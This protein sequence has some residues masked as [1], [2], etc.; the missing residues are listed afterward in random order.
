MQQKR[1][2]SAAED[3]PS[4]EAPDEEHPR[5]LIPELYRQF[6]Y[7][8]W[9]TGSGGSVS[10]KMDDEI[11]VAPSGVQKEKIKPEDMF[12]FDADGNEVSGPTPSKKLR[13]SSCFPV[14]M[15][16]FKKRGAG[17]V[18]HTHSPKA[19][20]ATLLWSG[21]EF[22]VANLQMI[23]AIPKG[24]SGKNYRYD[25][26]LVVPI[27]EN[28]PEE[29]DLRDPMGAAIDEYP[30]TSAVLV[31]GHG[32]YVWGST[33]QKAKIICE[34]YDYLFGISVEMKRHGLL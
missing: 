6:Y 13:P 18:I 25:E 20:L 32:L 23:K 8:G 30:D 34:A 7:L 3:H 2:C 14:F 15:N 28:R 31:R 19:V 17:A 21:K 26:E 24:Q 9:T 10:I 16:A 27:I 22:R 29:I 11:Y 1:T 12:I 33:W 4:S 5:K